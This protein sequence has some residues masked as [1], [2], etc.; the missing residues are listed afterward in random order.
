MATG[1]FSARVKMQIEG[2]NRVRY[3][4]SERTALEIF[5]EVNIRLARQHAPT[6]SA[7]LTPVRGHEGLHPPATLQFTPHGGVAIR[8]S[9]G[10]DEVRRD[11]L[12]SA[13][14]GAQ[15]QPQPH[16]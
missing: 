15:P 4:K 10:P 16:P 11:A 2:S 3:L 8:R 13:L 14:F 7:S 1:K 6:R 12:T 5:R 9:I